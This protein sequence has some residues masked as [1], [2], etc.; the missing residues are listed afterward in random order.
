MRKRANPKATRMQLSEHLLEEVINEVRELRIE[1]RNLKAE[2]RKA[3]AEP[4]K[5][6]ESNEL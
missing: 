4:R 5:A 2:V 1:V 3:N 6:K